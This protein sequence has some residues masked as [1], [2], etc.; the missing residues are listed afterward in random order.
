[1]KNKT[2]IKILILVL[3]FLIIG[4][5]VTNKIIYL[6][7]IKK[8]DNNTIHMTTAEE[9]IM[10][11]TQTYPTQILIYGN[12]IDFDSKLNITYINEIS[13]DSLKFDNNFSYQ[14]II[15]NDLDDQINISDKELTLIGEIVRSNKHCNFI[16]LGSKELYKIK[17][18]GI[19]IEELYY[20]PGDLSVGLFY[21]NDEL[22]SVLGT[23]TTNSTSV[24][25]A[26]LHQHVYFIKMSNK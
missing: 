13:K 12:K 15:I 5:F 22:I 10:I 18:S 3:V 21:E 9:D 2:K 7:K 25:K 19:L 24:S 6:Y 11:A 4:V 14:Y 17:N 16:Y 26:I 20:N 8:V 1:M 23:Y